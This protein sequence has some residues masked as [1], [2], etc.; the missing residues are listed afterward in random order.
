VGQA[1]GNSIPLAL[2][3]AISPIPIIAVILML[4]S[5]RAG[6]NSAS[7][8][9]GWIVGIAGALTI[10]IAVAGSI[11]TT[12]DGTPSSGS[13]TTKIILG[14]LLIGL[15][16]RDWRKRPRPGQPAP[17]PKWLRAMEDISPIKSLALGLALSAINPKNLIM[18]VGGGVAI[19]Q[20][21]ASSGD[22]IVAAVVF[23]VIAASTV[24]LPM[25]LKWSLGVRAQPTLDSLKAWLEANNAT[26]MAVLF[27]V[28]GIVLIGKGM[29]SQ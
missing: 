15:G 19:S 17:L 13:S 2:G 29:A 5:K 10:V 7:F 18:I 28:I 1:I 25:V 24:I 6:V 3:V 23:V 21:S 8:T 14:V 22:R 16:F 20:A 26:V 11:G 9:L 27:L 12:T 4:L